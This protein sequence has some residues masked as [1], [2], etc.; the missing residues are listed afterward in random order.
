MGVAERIDQRLAADPVRFIAKQRVQR[1]GLT[2]HDD[3]EFD[4]FCWLITRRKLFL[5]SREGLFQVE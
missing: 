4:C 1:S 2:L 5:D 3:T